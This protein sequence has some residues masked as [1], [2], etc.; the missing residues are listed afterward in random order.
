MTRGS[1]LVER[2]E[3]TVISSVGVIEGTSSSPTFT[4]F[5]ITW[6]WAK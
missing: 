1:S 5:M 2:I 3:R 6:F 4:L